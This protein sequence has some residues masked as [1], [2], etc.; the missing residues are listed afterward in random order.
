MY[1]IKKVRADQVIDFAAGELKKYLH[2]MMPDTPNIPITYE[3]DAKDGFRLGLLEDFGLPNEAEDVILDD[4]VHVDTDEKGG[5]LA[6]SNPRSVLFAVY[7]YLR[8]NGCRWLFAGL[9]GEFIP[10]QTVT[11]QKY[12]KLADFRYRGHTT[13]GDPSF[14]SIMDYIDFHPKLELNQYGLYS[15]HTYHYRYYNHDHNEAN[16]P[17][18]SVS[19]SVIDQYRGLFQT[20]ILKRGLICGGGGGH[21]QLAISVG[22]DPADRAAYKSGEKKIPEEIRPYLAMLNGKRDLY[23]NDIY[24]T[25]MCMSNAEWRKKYVQQLADNAEKNTVSRL[26][27]VPLAD[28]NHNHCEC[29]ECVKLRPS[30]FRVMMLNDLDEELIRRGIK[31]KISFSTYVDAMFTPIQERLKNPSHF[32]ISFAPITRSYTSS[33]TKD[34]VIPEPKPYR[35]RNDWDPPKSI[36]EC[37]SH[38]LAWKKLC[39]NKCSSSCFDY[40]F[41]RAQYRDPGLM[42][43]S[44]RIYEDVL[45]LRLLGIDGYMQDGSNKSF[46]PNGFHHYIYAEALTNIDCDYEAVMEDY[47]SHMYGNDWKKVKAY[48]TGISEAFGEKYM[49]GEDSADPAVGTH[50]NPER[51][52]ALRKVNELAAMARELAKKNSIMPNRP[53]TVAYQILNRHAEYCQILADVFI[54]K[55]NGNNKYALEMFTQRFRDFGKYDYEMERYLDFGLAVRT[56]EVVVKQMPKIEF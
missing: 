25:N 11:P 46:F 34:T 18:E 40:H 24:F 54:E 53:Q 49:A 45:S 52:V 10:L 17:K 41:W 8:L 21:E 26:A 3:P 13:E 1:T 27:S 38:L 6:G 20:E 9:D 4:V 44:R 7:R 32:H 33:I 28:G 37:A 14:Q 30:D 22:L 36:E 31:K 56:L 16:R 55:A 47:F 39:D 48:L 5:I 12:H 43:I 19:A 15:I 42:Y 51:A 35:G 2:M 23:R 50:Y 29:E